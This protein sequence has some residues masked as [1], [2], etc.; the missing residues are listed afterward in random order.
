MSPKAVIGGSVV[1]QAIGRLAP[2]GL[3]GIHV[4]LPATVPA[5]VAAALASGGPP[6]DG[7]SEEERAT[8]DKLAAGSKTG[9]RPY[10]AMLTARPQNM[11]YGMADSPAGLA[12]WMLVH[13]GFTQWTYQDDAERIP[14]KDRCSTT[15]RCIGLRTRGPRQE[16][17]TGRTM[18]VTRQA[19]Q[20]SAPP[21][22]RFRWRSPRSLARAISAAQLGRARVPRPQLL[23]QGREGRPLCG[24]GRAGALQPRDPCGVQV[25][26][27]MAIFEHVH[28]PSLSG[29]TG[30]LNSEPL[31]RRAARPPA[32]PPTRRGARQDG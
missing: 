30:W 6:P 12:A 11:G 15:S 5:E 4:N 18:E 21:R 32:R 24:L 2:P 20:R 23:Q 29:A 9:G 8:F 22:S 17:C 14:T 10:F 25:G 1:A 19:P 28:L 7:L 16:G 27:L 13:G 3:L 26:A 31:G